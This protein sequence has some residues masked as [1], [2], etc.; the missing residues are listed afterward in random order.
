MTETLSRFGVPGTGASGMLQP[1]PRHRFRVVVVN[2]G[3]GSNQGDLSRQ[4]MTVGKPTVNYEPVVVDSYN[5]KAYY[6]GK[7]EWDTIQLVVRDDIS[8]AVSKLVAEQQ[9]KQL[10]HFEQTGFVAGVNYKFTMFIDTLDGGNTVGT[11]GTNG[12]PGANNG[13]LERWTIEGCFLT[14]VSYGDLDYSSSDPQT[15]TMTIRPDN[16]TYFGH[17]DTQILMPTGAANKESMPGRPASAVG[18][19]ALL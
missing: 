9:Q 2:F 8:N 6:S 18:P 19:T 10:N 13:I 17:N 7:H 11:P 5:S 12:I 1:K 16:C 14:N 15:I 4:V 3:S